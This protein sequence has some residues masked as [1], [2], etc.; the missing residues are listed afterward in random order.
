[1]ALF[2]LVHGGWS[3]AH[4]FR[5]VRTLLRAAGHEVFTPSLTGIGERAHLTSPSVNLTTHIRDVVNVVLY[6]DLDDITLLGFSYGGMV[7]TGALDHIADRVR[8]LVYLDAFVPANSDTVAGLAGLGAI[9]TITLDAGWLVPPP[10]REFDEPDE[11]TWQNERRTPHPLGCF[12][13]AVH[14]AQLTGPVRRSM[15]TR[16]LRALTAASTTCSPLS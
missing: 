10:P 12:T 11:A 1:M 13:E 15:P 9:P 5:N 7:V 3:G 16:R 4:G 2:V 14:L 6:E 8:H